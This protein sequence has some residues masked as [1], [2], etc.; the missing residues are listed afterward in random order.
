[1]RMKTCRLLFALI[2]IVGL[3][4]HVGC[5]SFMTDPAVRLAYCLEGAVKDAGASAT[6]QANCDLKISGSYLVVLH[7]AG[8]VSDAQLTA[9]GVSPDVVQE[10]RALRIADR[11]AIYV[12]SVDA[13]V[14]GTG[15]GRSVLSSRTTY[16]NN[17]IRIDRLMA[18]VKTSPPVN[19]TIGGAA[20]ARVIEDIR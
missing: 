19:V 15:T 10:V 11:P 4:P 5:G 6:A 13:G 2:V 14:T 18:V 17:F 9:A 1:M 3:T 8:E 16:Q 20:G 7:P 12:V